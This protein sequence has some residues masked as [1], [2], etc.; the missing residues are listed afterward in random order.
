MPKSAE[1]T[2]H[3]KARV[4]ITLAKQQEDGDSPIKM[5]YQVCWREVGAEL[6]DGLRKFIG[7]DNNA[8]LKSRG[9]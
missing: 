6:M 1:R 3:R 7:V 8:A 9:P 4:T 2:L 5:L